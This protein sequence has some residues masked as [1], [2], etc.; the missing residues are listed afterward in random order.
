MILNYELISN[1]VSKT[2]LILEIKGKGKI[3]CELKRH[4][5]PRTVGI[6]LRSLP[7]EGNAHFFGKSIV[8]LETP[9]DSG[10]ERPKKEFKKGE[11]AF[12]PSGGSMCF[13]L[14]DSSP[15]KTMTP[16]GKIISNSETL[17]GVKPGDVL[18]FYAET[19]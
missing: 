15:G 6:I 17:G 16:I 8:Y 5:S 18:L 4:L 9:I 12:L 14:T 7:L 11:I 1:S 3:E 10:I 2:R 13:F 19:G